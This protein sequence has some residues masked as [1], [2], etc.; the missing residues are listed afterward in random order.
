MMQMCQPILLTSRGR[1]SLARSL[2]R[3]EA[4][5]PKLALHASISPSCLH[6]AYRFGNGTRIESKDRSLIRQRVHRTKGAIWS[7]RSWSAAGK[8]W[9]K[10]LQLTRPDSRPLHPHENRR[11]RGG[12]NQTFLLASES[13]TDAGE[14]RIRLAEHVKRLQ[15]PLLRAG[16]QAPELRMGLHCCCNDIL[17]PFRC[18]AFLRAITMNH[19]A[20][21]MKLAGLI[22]SQMM[23]MLNTTRI[24][25]PRLHHRH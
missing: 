3:A 15:K 4:L 11:A 10:K 9:K 6:H 12:K 7:A 8:S 16:E 20:S 19:F 13:S 2:H 23:E 5:L 14:K 24:L 25:L 17:V 1:M 18:D 21:R 22:P